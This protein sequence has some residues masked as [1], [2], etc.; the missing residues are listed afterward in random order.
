MFALAIGKRFGV[1]D[2][3]S[4]FRAFR[5]PVA[6]SIQFGRTETYG[7]KF[8]IRAWLA[9]GSVRSAWS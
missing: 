3:L 1:H 7:A 2:I 6:K 4:N 8:L 5:K 9:T